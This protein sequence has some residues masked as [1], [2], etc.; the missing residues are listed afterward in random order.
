MSNYFDPGTGDFVLVDGNIVERDTLHI[1]ERIKEYD[2][3]LE[4]LCL[5]PDKAG[6]NDAPFVICERM[7]N[8]SL[9]RIF[10]CW[11]L[12]NSVIERIALADQHKFNALTRVEEL[13]AAFKK[14]REARYK[15]RADE[16]KDIMAHAVK[17]RTSSYTI[18]NHENELVTI[19]ERAPVKR[20]RGRTY[21]HS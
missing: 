3:N 20:N 13:E 16:M 6:L 7:P 9:Q 18:R 11:V 17:N 5:D 15:D 14:D 21:S 12:D 8:G 4:I 2:E 1:A 19:D 10:E